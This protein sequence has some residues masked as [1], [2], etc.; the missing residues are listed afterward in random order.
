MGHIAVTVI[1]DGD[2]A[3]APKPVAEN[4]FALKYRGDVGAHRGTD[5]NPAPVQICARPGVPKL[6]PNFSLQRTGQLALG[7]SEG[8][9]IKVDVW[10]RS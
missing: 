4:D 8:F 9:A 3:K 10:V 7:G 2:K 6:V 5:I 1:H